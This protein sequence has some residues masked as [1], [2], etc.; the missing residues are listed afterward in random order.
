MALAART[1]T[2]RV[3]GPRQ[4]QDGRAGVLLEPPE[5]RPEP[6]ADRLVDGVAGLRPVDHQPD[7]AVL[8]LVGDRLT[9]R[10]PPRA[11]P[12]WSRRPPPGP[13]RPAP[14]APFPPARP[15]SGARSSSPRPGPPPPRPRPAP[16]PGPPPAGRPPATATPSPHPLR[17]RDPRAPSNPAIPRRVPRWGNVADHRNRGGRLSTAPRAPRQRPAGGRPGPEGGRLGPAGGAQGVPSGP[18]FG[19]A[20]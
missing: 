5:P 1:G 19:S 20:R 8:E 15:R 18:G 2:E 7:H 17:H 4:H 9:H 6:V 12:P 16:R 11:R 13:R 14:A 10:R 3:P